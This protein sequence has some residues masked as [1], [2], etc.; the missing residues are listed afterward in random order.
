MFI[1]QIFKCFKSQIHT[2][3]K[4]YLPLQ[5]FTFK[6]MAK[7][8]QEEQEEVI[9]DIGGTYNKVEQF[10]EAKKKPISMAVGAI[11]VIVAIVFSYNKFYLEP[12][13]Q[14]AGVQIWK[15]Q[16]YFQND[17]LDLA[18]M[19]DD[20][21][22]GFEAIKSDYGSTKSGELADYYT[23]LIYFKQ[24]E[25]EAAIEHL[26]SFSSD[27]IIVSAIALG[28]IGDCHAELGNL[29]DAANYYLKASRKHKND[30]STPVYLMKAGLAF[31]SVENYSTAK[32]L[33]K[34]LMDDYASTTEGRNA[35]K[36]Y[37][38][39]KTLAENS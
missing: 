13:E 34:E 15:A 24:G 19:G 22:M 32:D 7:R 30:F 21:Y 28:A 16:Q 18:L 20:N 27:D 39:A 4:V 6:S 17:S 29:S 9:V 35:E 31:E 10:I 36:Y 12:L 8:N 1:S 25:Y 14:D 26:S 2:I 3:K 33:Y 23:G 37:Y 38:R 5:I 11:V